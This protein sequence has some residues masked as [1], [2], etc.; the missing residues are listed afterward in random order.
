[1][2]IE[3]LT[4]KIH[5]LDIVGFNDKIDSKDGSNLASLTTASNI[6]ML[7]KKIFNIKEFKFNIFN[8]E[9]EVFNF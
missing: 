3:N 7:I 4:N 2:I 1:M 6:Q 9:T 5:S 8:E